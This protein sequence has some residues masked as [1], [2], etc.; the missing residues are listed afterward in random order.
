LTADYHQLADYTLNRRVLPYNRMPRAY[1]NWEQPFGKWLAAGIDAEAVRFQDPVQ[2]GGSRVD[3]K[4]FVSMPLSGA[5][6]YVTPTLAWR[7][8]AYRIDEALAPGGNTSPIRSLPIASLDAGLYFDRE[9]SWRGESFLQTLEPRLF[10]LR[11]PYR[12]QS[13]LPLDSCSAKTAT[14]VRTAKPTPTSSRWR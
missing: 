1:F 11:V 13:E 9:A 5:S 7:Y 2:A 3:L 12:D 14:R 8:T 6:W 4:P 10:Y